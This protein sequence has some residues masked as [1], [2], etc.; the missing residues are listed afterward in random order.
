LS[1]RSEDPPPARNP[2]PLS[3]NHKIE[4][5]VSELIPR[6]SPKRSSPEG[7]PPPESLEEGGEVEPP[8]PT[9]GG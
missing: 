8:Y 5:Q 7:R 1:R 6:D 2:P 9:D 4:K 3:P